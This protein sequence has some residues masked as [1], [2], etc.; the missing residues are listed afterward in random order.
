MATEM[1]TPCLR[2]LESLGP[3]IEQL[4]IESGLAILAAD[5]LRLARF[6]DLTVRIPHRT[7]LAMLDNAIAVSRDPGFALHAGA[8]AQPG[9]FGV[10]EMLARTAPTLGA[11]MQVAARYVS[12]LHD[13]AQVSIER[14]GEQA[15][16]RHTLRAD[17]AQSP[18]ANEY[19]VAAFNFMALRMLGLDVPPLEVSFMH[20]APP[21][22]QQYELLFKTQVRFGCPSNAIVMPALALDLPLRTADAPMHAV[23]LRYA[24]DQL[25][26]L[27]TLQP[28]TK[29]VRELLRARLS[30]AAGLNDVAQTL[31]MSESTVRRRLVAEGT[32]HSEL[33]DGLRREVALELLAQPELDVAEIGFR[34]GFA[35]PPAFHRA[36]KRWYGMSPS[37]HRA[38]GTRSVFYRFHSGGRK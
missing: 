32:S 9:D 3:E 21:H 29:Q 5:G 19:V 17:L 30:N 7:A 8:G 27:P 12:L 18:G 24:D 38:L 25:A 4:A 36:F 26:R 34:L 37:E 14:D 23:L 11:S 2:R 22:A 13:G 6:S 35:H 10:V 1:L 31:H 33:L 16:W 20:A 15:L 28:F